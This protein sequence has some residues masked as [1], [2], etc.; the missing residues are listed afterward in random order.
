VLPPALSE[1]PS[2]GGST[3]IKRM[4]REVQREVSSGTA[5]LRAHIGGLTGVALDRKTVDKA[6]R[7][8]GKHPAGKLAH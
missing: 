8:F 5:L 1:V 2:G 6:I 7:K 3:R 4:Q